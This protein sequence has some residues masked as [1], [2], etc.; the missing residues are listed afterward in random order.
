MDRHGQFKPAA[1]LLRQKIREIGEARGFSATRLLTHWTEIVGA[2]VAAI[3][4][5]LEV[6][7]PRPGK[8]AP[9]GATLTVLALGAAALRLEMEKERIRERVN[10]CYGYNAIGRIKIKQAGPESFAEEAAPAPKPS[11]PQP[12]DEVAPLTE[13]VSNTELRLALAA[14][15]ANVLSKSRP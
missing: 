10:A 15:A 12:L 14:L 13:G 1:D 4:R 11:S 9:E 6:R 2:S 5:P 8:G 7:H 3:A